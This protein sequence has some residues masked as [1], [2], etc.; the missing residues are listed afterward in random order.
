MKHE[1]KNHK[2]IVTIDRNGYRFTIE[3]DILEL[4]FDF[5]NKIDECVSK[6]ESI[7]EDLHTYINNLATDIY[8]WWWEEEYDNMYREAYK[9]LFE[10]VEAQYEEAE[11]EEEEARKEQSLFEKTHRYQ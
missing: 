11:K 4:E 8:N 9:P 7:L 2:F 5:E 3:K 1:I 6:T 10:Y